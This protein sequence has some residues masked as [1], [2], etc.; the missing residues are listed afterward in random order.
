MTKDISGGGL[1]IRI[2]GA[3]IAGIWKEFDVGSVVR[4]IG[5]LFVSPYP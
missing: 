5:R 1:C 2:E 3:E 4:F